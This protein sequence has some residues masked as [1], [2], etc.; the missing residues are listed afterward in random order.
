MEA[1]RRFARPRLHF[2]LEVNPGAAAPT[3]TQV[4][5]RQGRVGRKARADA[6]DGAAS[7]G[8]A[9][10]DAPQPFSGTMPMPTML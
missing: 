10:D 9:P 4:K 1:A 5:P 8:E 6:G 3:L 2:R 7:P